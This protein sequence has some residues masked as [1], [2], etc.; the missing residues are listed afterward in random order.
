MVRMQADGK[1]PVDQRRGYKN[2]LDGLIRMTREEGVFSMFRVGYK[3]P[4]REG[5][6]GVSEEERRD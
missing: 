4:Y 1:L 5:G 3:F 6:L 2:V